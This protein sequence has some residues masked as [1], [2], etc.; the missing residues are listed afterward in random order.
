MDWEYDAASRHNSGQ[1][2]SSTSHSI[3]KEFS[4]LLGNMY[5]QL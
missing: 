4:A 3:A 2:F 1:I 5:L